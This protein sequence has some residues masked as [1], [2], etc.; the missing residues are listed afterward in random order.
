MR[1]VFSIQNVF[2]IGKPALRSGLASTRFGLITVAVIAVG[3]ALLT[4]LPSDAY[5]QPITHPVK[6]IADSVTK[7]SP[8]AD[9][10][11]AVS[12]VRKGLETVSSG[13]LSPISDQPASPSPVAPVSQAPEASEPAPALTSTSDWGSSSETP[14][15][16]DPEP[17]IYEVPAAEPEPTGAPASEPV[18]EA[19]AAEPAPAPEAPADEQPPAPPN[20]DD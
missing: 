5:N 7:G 3:V 14:V 6:A 19:P 8:T 2:S 16:S 11:K 1:N 15:A 4:W 20:F 17:S 9:E 12:V 10:S 18:P 13:I